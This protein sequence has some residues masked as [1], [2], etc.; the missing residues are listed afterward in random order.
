VQNLAN[1]AVQA[2]A[3]RPAT[4]TINQGTVI[5]VYVAKDVDFSGVVA[6]F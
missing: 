4:V 2:S 3:N 6:R 1:Q 5:Y